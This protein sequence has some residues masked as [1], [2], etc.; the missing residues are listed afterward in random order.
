MW[1]SCCSFTFL[2]FICPSIYNRTSMTGH[3]IN[4]IIASPS[5]LR[6][7]ISLSLSL[8]LLLSLHLLPQVRH[9]EPLTIKGTIYQYQEYMHAD[10][11]LWIAS[12]PSL[13]PFP[14]L[15]LSLYNHLHSHARPLTLGISYNLSHGHSGPKTYRIIRSIK[16]INFWS[17]SAIAT[18]EHSGRITTTCLTQ[19]KHT[20]CGWRGGFTWPF[21]S[22]GH[23][24]RRC[25]SSTFFM[26]KITF[27]SLS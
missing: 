10:W 14:C 24:Y 19:Y 20:R 11:R 12:S 9:D 15:S 26:N 21:R 18:H 25:K 22:N 6:P 27:R 13:L 8:Q 3:S 17:A 4:L 16:P 23:Q 1:W 2:S 5:Q 7:P